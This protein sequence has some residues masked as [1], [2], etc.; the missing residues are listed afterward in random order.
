M[1][2]TFQECG[3]VAADYNGMRPGKASRFIINKVCDFVMNTICPNVDEHDALLYPELSHVD[4]TMHTI[5][6]EVQ[7]HTIH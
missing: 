6:I 5:T 4:F 1:I 7:Q 2:L 3:I